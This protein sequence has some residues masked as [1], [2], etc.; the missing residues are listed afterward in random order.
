METKVTRMFERY[1]EVIFFKDSF[2]QSTKETKRREI[3][4]DSNSTF[5]RV[6]VSKYLSHIKDEVMIELYNLD[7]DTFNLIKTY[8]TV[9]VNVGYK[10]KRTSNSSE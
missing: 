10:I 7:E 5:M 4:L 2:D 1:I 3:I 8:D 6:R 9:T